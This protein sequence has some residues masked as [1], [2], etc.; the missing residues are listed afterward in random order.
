LIQD[1]LQELRQACISLKQT[2][3]CFAVNGNLIRRHPLSSVVVAEQFFL[4]GS[5]YAEE[6]EASFCALGWLASQAPIRP[7]AFPA[8]IGHHCTAV[9]PPFREPPAERTKSRSGYADPI[10]ERL[11]DVEQARAPKQQALAIYE[12][13]GLADDAARV[14]AVLARLEGSNAPPPVPLPAN[15]TTAPMPAPMPAL[16][17]RPRQRHLPAASQ[18]WRSRTLQRSKRSGGGGLCPKKRVNSK[19]LMLPKK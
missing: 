11:G 19:M 2:M 1:L 3:Q 17:P 18:S 16:T 10:Y 15:P 12:E 5:V 6:P 4:Y 8:R 9:W 14:S 7:T 13:L